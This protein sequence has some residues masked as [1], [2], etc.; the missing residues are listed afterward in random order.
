[1]GQDGNRRA[2]K[3]SD[4]DGNTEAQRSCF[5]SQNLKVPRGQINTV[6]FR[7]SPASPA[8]FPRTPWVRALAALQVATVGA[9]LWRGPAF[10]APGLQHSPVEVRMGSFLASPLIHGRLTLAFSLPCPHFPVP[11]RGARTRSWAF[12][13]GRLALVF[14]SAYNPT[15]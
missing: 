7:V 9:F 11:C 13:G 8:W 3:H 12:H 14:V 1:M 6:Y 15:L 2:A 4:F 5:K 10:S